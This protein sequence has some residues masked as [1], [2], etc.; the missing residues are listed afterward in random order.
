MSVQIVKGDKQ[1]FALHFI[2]IKYSKPPSSSRFLHH[3]D[4]QTP[5]LTHTNTHTQDV[6]EDDGTLRPEPHPHIHAAW[7]IDTR[8]H[9]HR[10][11]CL[12]TQTHTQTHLQLQQCQSLHSTVCLVESGGIALRLSLNKI[13]NPH[14]NKHTW[15]GRTLVESYRMGEMEQQSW[16]RKLELE[17]EKEKIIELTRYLIERHGSF[18][19]RMTQL[20]LKSSDRESDG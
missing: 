15:T 5:T 18:L 9:A 2:P 16:K 20:D 6:I 8:A 11:A 17:R 19:Q 14:L 12:H 4:T 10:R 13:Q 7:T 3:T 1:W